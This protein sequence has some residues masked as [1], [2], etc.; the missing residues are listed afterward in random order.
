MLHRMRLEEE[1]RHHAEVA[2]AAA[3]RPE[4]IGMLALAGGHDAAIGKDDV[5]FEQV[6]DRQPVLAREIAG[7]AA[8]RQA[9]DARRRD[10]AEGNGEAEGMSRVIDVA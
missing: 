2:A 5:G 3:N 6:V 9:G 4:Q 7:S 1:A 8:K 10:D